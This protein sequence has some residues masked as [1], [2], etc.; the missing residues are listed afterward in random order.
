MKILSLSASIMIAGLIS[1]A[2]YAKEYKD[3]KVE[4][5]Q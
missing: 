1:L 4:Y 5:F 2:S 3:M